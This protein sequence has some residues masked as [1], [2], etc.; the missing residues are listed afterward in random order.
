MVTK[1]ADT[2]LSVVSAGL[3]VSEGTS[4]DS[5]L[6]GGVGVDGVGESAIAS[7]LAVTKL[8]EL[9]DTGLRR[10]SVIPQLSW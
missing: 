4:T 5:A 3:R 7:K 9:T 1:S 6:N 2:I 10:H 8:M